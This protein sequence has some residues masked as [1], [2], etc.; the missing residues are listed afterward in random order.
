MNEFLTLR[1]YWH[2]EVPERWQKM[3][4]LLADVYVRPRED[5]Q[6]MKTVNIPL[7]RVEP[8]FETV[9]WFNAIYQEVIGDPKWTCGEMTKSGG[10]CKKKDKFK[11]PLYMVD[12]SHKSAITLHLVMHWGSFRILIGTNPHEKGAVTG[13]EAFLTFVNCC[14]KYGINLEDYAI[15]NGAYVKEQIE[16]PRIELAKERYLNVVYEDAHHLDLNSSY[17]TGIAQAFPELYPPI[18]EIYD[19]RKEDP[20]NKSVLTNTFGF[21]QSKWCNINGKHYAL[22]HLSKA[23][24]EYN[25][26]VID[27]LT[28]KLKKSGRRVIAYNT[29]GIWYDGEIY[30][31][32]TE[33]T[34]LGQWKNDHTNCTLRFKSAGAYEYIDGD[35][36]YPVVRG[37]TNLDKIKPRS[38]W[39]WGDIFTDDAELLLWKYQENIGIVTVNSKKEKYNN[40]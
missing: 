30:H 19:K 12:T 39:K 1:E 25:N 13:R 16:S 3:F 9:E 27:E 5:R 24:I 14:K 35:T 26:R 17:M 28:D 7:Y 21:C 32:E 10:I 33:G 20:K 11:I 23:A 34:D 8:T 40:G 15:D 4:D 31:D 2:E 22:A 36:Y 6:K 18:K 29:D 37:I 38:E